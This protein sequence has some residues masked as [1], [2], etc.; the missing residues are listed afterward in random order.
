MVGYYIGL[1]NQYCFVFEVFFFLI[2]EGL[3]GLGVSCLGGGG[4][5]LVC[6]SVECHAVLWCCFI[7]FS[8]LYTNPIHYGR[9]HM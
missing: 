8:M 9:H 1:V 6:C 4:G 2:G 7:T 3:L 5:V